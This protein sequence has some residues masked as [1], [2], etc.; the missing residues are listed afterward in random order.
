MSASEGFL[1]VMRIGMAVVGN[2]TG[3][4]LKGVRGQEHI[5]ALGNDDTD[6]ILKG[7][8]DFEGTARHAYICG[9]WLDYFKQDCTEF[10]LEVYPR[11]MYSDTCVIVARM[12][13]KRY[14][15]LEMS[16]ESNMAVIEGIGF[17]LYNVGTGASDLAQEIVHWVKDPDDTIG[18]YSSIVLPDLADVVVNDGFQIEDSLITLGHVYVMIIPAATGNMRW[19]VDTNFGDPCVEDYDAHSDSIAA[20]QT[21]V[22]INKINCIDITAAL[23]GVSLGDVVG[24]EFTRYATSGLD[25]VDDECHFVGILLTRA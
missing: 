3:V 22:T 10:N 6:K 9:E 14:Q 16:A 12:V 4:S 1:G 23:T 25:T 2:L 5:R 15:I 21:A 17:D 11:G 7:K 19:G 24:L 13:I 18:R 8:R 20:N